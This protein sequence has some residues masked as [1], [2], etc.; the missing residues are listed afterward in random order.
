VSIVQ[1]GVGVGVEIMQVEV[2]ML[3]ANLL[4]LPVK[5]QVVVELED[6][7][8]P[9]ELRMG[10][11]VLSI[12]EEIIQIMVE[13]VEEDTMEEGQELVVVAIFIRVVVDH[14]TLL[15]V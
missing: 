11:L 4:I 5:E 13:E 7:M 15:I 12:L 2:V 10:R 14:L 1:V 6:L 8:G 3:E 9:V